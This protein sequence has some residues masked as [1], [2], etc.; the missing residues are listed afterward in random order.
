MYKFDL[1]YFI[2][3]GLSGISC[4]LYDDIADN[5]LFIQSKYR[6]FGL[7]FLKTFHSMAFIAIGSQ[8]FYYAI[9]LG[10]FNLICCIYDRSAWINQSYEQGALACACLF[11]PILLI[12]MQMQLKQNVNIQE[13]TTWDILLT[14][15]ICLISIGEYSCKSMKTEA[16][17]WKFGFRLY[18]I[19]ICSYGIWL[20]SLLYSPI[21]SNHFIF[22]ILYLISYA[23]TSCT[24]QAWKLFQPSIKLIALQKQLTELT[25]NLKISTL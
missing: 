1:F 14:I 8:Y 18:S 15:T 25:E 23:A 5:G 4:K 2:L 11:L 17:I 19:Y 3:A 24:F 21:F 7:E 16:S 6:Q 12:T 13:Y 9:F 10:L 22:F 20:N